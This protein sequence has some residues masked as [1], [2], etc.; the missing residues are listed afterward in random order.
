MPIIWDKKTS[1]RKTTKVSF[2]WTVSRS[3]RTALKALEDWW[4]QISPANHSLWTS[5]HHMTS[6]KNALIRAKKWLNQP[7]LI[8]HLVRIK[9]QFKRQSRPIHSA[10]VVVVSVCHKVPQKYWQAYRRTFQS[11]E[12]LPARVTAILRLAT[13]ECRQ[14]QSQVSGKFLASTGR[15]I[16][17]VKMCRPASRNRP[18]TF[19]KRPTSSKIHPL[20]SRA[21]KCEKRRKS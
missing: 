9:W 14:P 16:R 4:C 3:V 21:R 8:C 11:W 12:N 6:C 15:W 5:K 18:T 10:L 1:V 13:K 19:A 2:Q 17:K 20:C 7:T